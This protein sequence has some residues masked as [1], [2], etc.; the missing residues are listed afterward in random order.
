MDHGQHAKAHVP[1]WLRSIL[2]ILFMVA[3]VVGLSIVMRLFVFVPYEIPSGSMEETIRI[4]D[5]VFSE[6]V[7]YYFRSPETG[8]IVT[9][10]D[11]DTHYPG[12]TLIKRV[13]ATEGQ[14]VDLQDGVV[15][16]DGQPLDEPYTNGKP[17]RPLARQAQ[18][19]EVS[20]PYTV[21]SGCVWVMGDN[22]TSS[23]DSRYFGA[24]AV[25]S[26]TGRAAL[27]YWPFNHFGL[28]S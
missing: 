14:V 12:R 28:L 27:V 22:R 6:K 23:Q 15:W 10:A 7:S 25:D 26:I 2:T 13:I 3:I 5:M 20:F 16:V 19:T 9:F 21:P 24:I 1:G 4:G 18:G 17:S 8:D 11:P